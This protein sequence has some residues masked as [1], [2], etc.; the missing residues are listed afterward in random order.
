M[1][2][3]RSDAARPG[4]SRG[5]ASHT[6][7]VYGVHAVRALLTRHPQRVLRVL[8]QRGRQDARA[9]EIER[10]ARAGGCALERI[11]AE[12]LAQRLG[13]VVHQGVVAEVQAL[14]PWDEEQLLAAVVPAP[15]ALLLALDG[16]QDPHNLGA[17]VRTADA[18]AAMA[19]VIPRDRAAPLNATARKAAAGAAESTPVAVVTNLARTLRL[20]K[21]AGLWI[22]GAAADAQQQ[23]RDIDLTGGRV[24]VVGAEGSGLRQLTRRHCD[25]L[26]RLP[27]LGAVESLNV[28]V[29]AG[30]LLYEALRQRQAR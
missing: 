5:D 29:A 9:Q 2:S 11:D 27:S 20:L 14:A 6:E 13:D 26:V 3:Q 15:G 1:N 24:L 21:E 16:V 17:C 25:W 10:A 22:V 8:L 30:M 7:L 18:C 12:R 28:S 4:A 23:A 19:V